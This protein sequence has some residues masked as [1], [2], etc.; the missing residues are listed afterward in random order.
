[1]VR[2]EEKEG[3]ETLNRVPFKVRKHFAKAFRKSKGSY[4]TDA[5]P[6]AL[7]RA[8]YNG[9]DYAL[10]EFLLQALSRSFLEDFLERFTLN[11]ITITPHCEHLVRVL[12]GMKTQLFFYQD[13]FCFG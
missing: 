3:L 6:L 8:A 9:S 1:M 13:K 12:L 4:L 2:P 5:A 11:C 7:A 10:L